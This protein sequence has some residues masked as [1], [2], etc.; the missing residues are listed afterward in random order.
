MALA[1]S[2]FCRPRVDDS[3]G[4]SNRYRASIFFFLGLDTRP[5]GKARFR[6]ASADRGEPDVQ[7]RGS[8]GRL[9]A[10]TVAK[11]FWAPE[12]ATLIQDRAL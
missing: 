10:D 12:R 9:M 11:V 7:A 4:H 5:T 2:V 1:R 3:S 8:V 6:R